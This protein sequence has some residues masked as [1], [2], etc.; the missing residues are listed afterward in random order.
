M[1]QTKTEQKTTSTT[2]AT[3]AKTTRKRTAS[4]SAKKQTAKTEPVEVKEETKTIKTFKP[5]TLVPCKSV[6]FG[7]LTYIGISGL[8][9]EWSGFGDIR[10]IPYQDIISLKSKRSPFLYQ[11]WLIIEDEDFLD[12]QNNRKEFGEMY[13][14]YESFE[15][16]TEFFNCTPEEMRE[17]LKN[18]P[19]GFKDLIIGSAGDLINRGEL[20]SIGMINVIDNALGTK[21]KMMLD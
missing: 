10:E 12:L 19:S 3:K 15:D 7:G 14:L 16:S 5:D 2:S 17:K 21:I 1:T 8:R 13:E 4:T 11:P 6:V 20:D 18:A 9:Y